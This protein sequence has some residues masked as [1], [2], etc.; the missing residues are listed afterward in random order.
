M[1]LETLVRIAHGRGVQ[2][3]NR[4]RAARIR[5]VDHRNAGMPLRVPCLGAT[6]LLHV[7]AV[8]EPGNLVLRSLPLVLPDELEIALETELRQAAQT[9]RRGGL[10]SQTRL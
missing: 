2:P 4:P 5:Y 3:L 6:V 8:A 7:G 9:L 1:D 10:P